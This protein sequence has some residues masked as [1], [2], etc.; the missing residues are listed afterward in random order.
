MRTP[1]LRRPLTA[2]IAT[3]TATA[4]SMLLTVPASS[5]ATGSSTPVLVRQSNH[6]VKKTAPMRKVRVTKLISNTPDKA[7]RVRVQLANGGS[8][9][10]RKP[11]RKR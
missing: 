11:P 9:P 1:Q 3:L 5:A 10:F 8:F 7:G 6:L 2:V 4:A